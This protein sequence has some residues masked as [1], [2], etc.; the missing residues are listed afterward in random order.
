[1]NVYYFYNELSTYNT[2]EGQT[3]LQNIFENV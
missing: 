3:N 2:L 1:M